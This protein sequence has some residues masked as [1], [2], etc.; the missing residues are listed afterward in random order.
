M[1]K[2]ICSICKVEKELN[3]EN[4]YWRE[5]RNVFE[6][7]CKECLR[8]KTRKLYHTDVKYK[9]EAIARTLRNR[10]IS[11]DYVWDYLKENP[12]L[13][14]GEPDPIVLQFDHRNPSDKRNA[15]SNLIRYWHPDIVKAEIEKCDV[16]C[17]NCHI[18]K[19]GKQFSWWKNGRDTKD[20]KEIC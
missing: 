15:I 8:A 11:R 20:S 14:C 10:K 12:C 2:K 13:D 5:G 9:D 7:R 4:F 18:R 19:T 16:R 3:K 17:A 1:N 6:S